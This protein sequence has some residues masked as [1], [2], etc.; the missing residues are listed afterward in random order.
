MEEGGIGHQKPFVHQVVHLEHGAQEPVAV[1][2][3]QGDQV[4]HAHHQVGQG[5]VVEG[6]HHP[7]QQGQHKGQEQEGHAQK[8]VHVHPRQG[9]SRPVLGG[10]DLI[11]VGDVTVEAGDEEEEQQPHGLH[12][13]AVLFAHHRMGQLMGGQTE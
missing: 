5:E 1:Q 13:P 12:F 11:D 9:H 7:P 8:G 3:D 6:Q 4:V 2:L 10:R